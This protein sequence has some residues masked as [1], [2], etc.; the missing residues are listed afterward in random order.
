M[1]IGPRVLSLLWPGR[2]D[3]PLTKPILKALFL[4]LLIL[5]LPFPEVR[6][7]FVL[8]C[9]WNERKWGKMISVIARTW[10][11]NPRCHSPQ[12]PPRRGWTPSSW[13]SWVDSWSWTRPPS[14]A[15]W[16]TCS[17]TWRPSLELAWCY[18]AKNKHKVGTLFFCA[19]YINTLHYNWSYLQ[20][21]SQVVDSDVQFINLEK[22][23]K[24]P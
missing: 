17:R 23:Q 4:P 9:S 16:R 12:A 7:R 15:A 24:W 2:T 3:L 14:S 22:R 21:S 6:L 5:I 20:F 1:D 8:T 10:T 18:L 19:K 13:R 11:C